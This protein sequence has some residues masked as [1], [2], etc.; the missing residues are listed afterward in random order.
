MNSRWVRVLNV[1]LKNAIIEI[2][3]WDTTEYYNP[4]RISKAWHEI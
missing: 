3:G 2:V 1:F 4:G